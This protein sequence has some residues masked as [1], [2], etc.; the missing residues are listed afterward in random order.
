M[1]TALMEQQ[2]E[3]LIGEP[4]T[5]EE[6]C[7]QIEQRRLLAKSKDLGP[8]PKSNPTA[9]DISECTREMVLGILHWQE[10]G[11]FT[12]EV[13]ARLDRGTKIEDLVIQE[14]RDLGYAV[15][16]DRLPFEIKDKKGRVICRGKVDGFIQIGRKEHPFEVKSLMPAIYARI[17]TE[18]DFDRYHFFK[19]YP[20]QL[21]TYLY[22]NNIEDGFFI[23]DDCLGHQKLIPVKLDYEKMEKILQQLEQA[24]EAIDRIRTGTPEDEALPDFHKDPQV[25]IKCH[26][27]K[28]VCMPPFS[29]GEGMQVLDDHELGAKLARLKELEDA[30]TEYDRYDREVKT[31]L[32][33]AMHDKQTF[34]IGDFLV[35]ADEKTRKMKA[36]AA[37]DAHEQKYLAFEIERLP[38]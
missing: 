36:Q 11:S 21:R 22:A 18:E 12:P 29:S 20:K 8:W 7:K 37:K 1:D 31:F 27:F 30:A 9:S 5:V 13:R 32:K 2:T 35:S 6:L 15:R 26:F 25:C 24:V 3:I 14:L 34:I 23:L 38:Y 17:N 4:Q 10:R 19:K 33:A 28:R 16:Q